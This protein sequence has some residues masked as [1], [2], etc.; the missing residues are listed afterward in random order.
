MCVYFSQL[1]FFKGKSVACHPVYHAEAMSG[2]D[3]A[4]CCLRWCPWD[5]CAAETAAAK[6]RT[7][8]GSDRIGEE[9]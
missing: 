6:K 8:T 4:V 1:T 9:N 5:W 2:D 3:D 7:A